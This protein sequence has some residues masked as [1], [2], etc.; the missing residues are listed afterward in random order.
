MPNNRD[1]QACWNNEPDFDFSIEQ[2]LGFYVYALRDPSTKKPFYIGKGGGDGSGNQ[3]IL[4][5]FREAKVHRERKTFDP[6]PK[7]I[8]IL[9]I[10]NAGKSVDWSIIRWGLPDEKTAL[11]IE[12]SLIDLVG[13]ESLTNLQ[14]GHASNEFGLLSPAELY[15]KMA[16]AVMPAA[17]YPAVLIFSIKNTFKERGLYEATRGW[18]RNTKKFEQSATHAV[19]VINGVSA[20]VVEIQ[21]WVDGEDEKR[22]GFEGKS[23]IEPGTHELLH[24]NFNHIINERIGSWQYGNW[25][26]VEF[27]SG[28][29][30]ILLG[31]KQT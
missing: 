8:K 2:S 11:H 25:L 7:V 16:P 17:N 18:W 22:R 20:C 10:W 27:S 28:A 19:G 4:D 26:A 21:N 12:A 14:K 9:E 31:K 6:S 30:S 23:Y 29:W 24:K 3:R 13:A 5:H 15:R 1:I